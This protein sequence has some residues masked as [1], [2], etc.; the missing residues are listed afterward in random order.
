MRVP[1]GIRPSFNEL[2][3]MLRVWILDGSFA[4][5]WLIWQIQLLF[6]F[7]MILV[8]GRWPISTS[9]NFCLMNKFGEALW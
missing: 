3:F 1:N 8:T 9:M 5:Y 6:T 4:R 7:T 2:I